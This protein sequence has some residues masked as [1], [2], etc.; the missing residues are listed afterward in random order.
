MRSRAIE[1]M[2]VPHRELHAL[3]RNVPIIAISDEAHLGQAA[4]FDAILRAEAR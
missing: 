4:D 3:H 1:C 2:V